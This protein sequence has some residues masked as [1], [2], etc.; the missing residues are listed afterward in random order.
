MAMWRIGGDAAGSGLESVFTDEEIA[1]LTAP[2]PEIKSDAELVAGLNA[3]AEDLTN[4][5]NVIATA[6]GRAAGRWNT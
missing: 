1:A 2:P 6:V 3:Q 4:R 5:L